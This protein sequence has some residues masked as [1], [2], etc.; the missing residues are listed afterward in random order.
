MACELLPSRSSRVC[1]LI[2][3]ALAA[4]AAGCQENSPTN[5]TAPTI[6]IEV[7]TPLKRD[8]VVP[9]EY[10]RGTTKAVQSVD[11]YCRVS[12]YLKKIGFADGEYVAKDD[13][14]HPQHPLFLIDDAPFKAAFDKAEA[15]VQVRKANREYRT[16]ELERKKSLPAGAVSKSELDQAIAAKDEAD[17][18][19]VSAEADREKASLDLKYTKIL[20]PINGR[21]SKAAISE[22]NLVVADK[23]LL[24]T[25]VSE[26]EMYVEFYIDEQTVLN[27]QQQIREGRIKTG[28]KKSVPVAIRL[29]NETGYVHEGQLNFFDNA[30]NSHTGTYLLRAV[31][32]NPKPA[33]GAR[34]LLP[35]M[36]VDVRLAVGMP[37]TSL[38]VADRAIGSDLD[39]KYVYV[40]NDKDQ[41]EKRM[42]ELGTLFDGLRVVKTGLAAG[43]QVIVVG[44]QNVVRPNVTIKKKIKKMTDYVASTEEPV[45]SENAGPSGAKP[46]AEAQ[47]GNA[48]E[49][50]SGQP[51]PATTAAKKGE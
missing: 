5:S 41:P 17:A 22:G 8:D 14:E 34:L 33:V 50:A 12:G 13:E 46:Q 36:S 23:T 7:A 51:K 3:S 40:L 25:I 4:L 31:F 37:E 19:V 32:P 18:A 39:Q 48:I 15:E 47:A 44:Q 29:G 42:V 24:S 30:L 10:A 28:D 27:V 9:Y 35:G 26:E 16:A 21:M 1:V 38:L 20:A 49:P 6:S 11:L 45:G 43:D 2:A